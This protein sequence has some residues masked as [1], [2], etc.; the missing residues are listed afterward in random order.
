MLARFLPGVAGLK[1]EFTFEFAFKLPFPF[2][3]AAPPPPFPLTLPFVLAPPPPFEKTIP[4]AV[5]LL[6]ISFNCSNDARATSSSGY[7][8]TIRCASRA[9]T[10]GLESTREALVLVLPLALLLEEEDPFA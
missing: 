6:E 1:F 10:N 8:P 3:L 7:D 2:A 4:A 9:A 5:A